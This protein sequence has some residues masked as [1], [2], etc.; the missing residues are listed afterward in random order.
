[1][2]LGVSQQK[3]L[4]LR[5]HDHP[6]PACGGRKQRVKHANRR[7]EKSGRWRMDRLANLL[8][9]LRSAGL[10]VLKLDFF[11]SSMPFIIEGLT[12]NGEDFAFRF[13]HDDAFL[14]IGRFELESG[15]IVDPRLSSSRIGVTGEP[16]A[17]FLS[18]ASQRALDR[19]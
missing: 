3:N 2:N 8:A 13:R 19:T 7:Q 5:H 6:L 11:G 17:G 10:P 16:Y 15:V 1:M 9:L 4:F 14:R 12:C 18:E